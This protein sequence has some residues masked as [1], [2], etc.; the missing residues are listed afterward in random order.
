MAQGV[1][2]PN[3]VEDPK[4]IKAKDQHADALMDRTGPG[5]WNQFTEQHSVHIT[6]IPP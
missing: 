6:Y 1:K 4:Q 5:S 3:Q 2:D